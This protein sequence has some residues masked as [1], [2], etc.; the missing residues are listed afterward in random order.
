M[1]QGDG[2]AVPQELSG[3]AEPSPCSTYKNN[4]KNVDM[5]STF[6]KSGYNLH[7]CISLDNYDV[8]QMYSEY[9]REYYQIVQ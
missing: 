2:S 8:I 6:L 4:I 9:C 5:M 3:T 7:S 1:E